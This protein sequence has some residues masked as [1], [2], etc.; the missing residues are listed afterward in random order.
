MRSVAVGGLLVLAVGCAG[1]GS[2]AEDGAP[3][4][5]RMAPI[6]PLSA[7]DADAPEV[8]TVH[9][10]ARI[11]MGSL[12]NGKDDKGGKDGGDACEPEPVCV[13]E[14]CVPGCTAGTIE[15]VWTW[16]APAGVLL[17]FGGVADGAGN[18]F[19]LEADGGNTACSVASLD[20]RG[21]ERFRGPIPCTTGPQQQLLDGDQFVVLQPERLIAVD[22]DDG[23]VAWTLESE[24][25]LECQHW[26][27]W[28]AAGPE[29]LYATEAIHCPNGTVDAREGW[30]LMA[31]DPAT[32]AIRWQHEERPAYRISFEPEY[33]VVADDA[34][35][36]WVQGFGLDDTH[37]A[38]LYESSFAASF[39]PDGTERW[40]SPLY[41]LGFGDPPFATEPIAV[42]FGTLELA[43][44]APGL[45]RWDAA[46]GAPLAS[47]AHD[48]TWI[49]SG[50]ALSSGLLVPDADTTFVA[51]FS[52]AELARYE[53]AAALW[54]RTFDALR[55][56]GARREVT[57]DQRGS[58]VFF[59]P[60][61]G[62]SD[63]FVAEVSGEGALVRRCELARP[64][65]PYAG[66]PVLRH[67]LFVSQTA[68]V[69]GL[70][71]Y[72]VPGLDEA[73]SGWTG[74]GGSSARQNR[75]R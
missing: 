8:G 69:A 67:G 32:G 72:A 37:D 5:E 46:T 22:A 48:P 63:D 23:S 26:F 68:G 52:K 33:T 36:A 29:T 19:W 14:A 35:N 13:P 4:S 66:V 41:R 10:P 28:M 56:A 71:A 74:P 30:A 31:I 54:S 44:G 21:H 51:D 11:A 27:E 25:D 55:I 24:R 40:R 2:P 3:L 64:L 57:L 7:P 12:P 75:V 49:S 73:A 65:D 20:L 42:A 58:L 70:A 38:G 53:G 18:L 9:P 59:G 61:A 50:G 15:P 62:S 45:D 1:S 16:E 34:D 60:A 47:L 39:A 6:P 43:F 17:R